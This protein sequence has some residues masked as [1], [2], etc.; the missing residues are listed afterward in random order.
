[1]AFCTNCGT[2]ISAEGKF[3][4]NCG[5]PVGESDRKPEPVVTPGTGSFQVPPQPKK[6]FPKK[7][8]IFGGGGLLAALLVVVLVTALWPFNLTAA[9]ARERLMAS[10]DFDFSVKLSDDQNSVADAEYPFLGIGDEC[11]AD[12]EIKEIIKRSGK[13]LSYIDYIEDSDSSGIAMFSEDVIEFESD[14][15]A[16]KIVELIR[17]AEGESTCSYD[18]TSDASTMTMYLKDFG[19]AQ[20]AYG[21]G[22]SNSVV[23]FADTIYDSTSNSWDFHWQNYKAVVA[24]GKYLIYINGMIDVDGSVDEV[25]IKSH[26]TK[27]IRK[28][29]G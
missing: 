1:M 2:E 8:A 14:A 13:V 26:I 16:S 28:L 15:D 22:G 9:Q 27:A 10:S 5:K 7:L 24:K 6:P 4:K 12:A 18:N 25:Q 20:D 17:G 21:V 29:L 11:T 23:Y 3:C 19:T